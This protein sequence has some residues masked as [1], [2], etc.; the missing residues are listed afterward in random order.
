[1][2]PQLK[3]KKLVNTYYGCNNVTQSQAIE[4][5]ERIILT[6]FCQQVDDLHGHVVVKNDYDM[7]LIISAINQLKIQQEIALEL[8]KMKP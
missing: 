3:A 8:Q 7:P 4:I 2:T 5:V 1:M 6:N